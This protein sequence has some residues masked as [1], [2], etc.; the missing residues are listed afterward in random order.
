MKKILIG[1]QEYA[2]KRLTRI[3]VAPFGS[4]LVK[5]KEKVLYRNDFAIVWQTDRICEFYTSGRKD[6]SQLSLFHYDFDDGRAEIL[7][8]E[9]SNLQEWEK[10]FIYLFDE[11][12][13]F[14]LYT[15]KKLE[16][17][18]VPRCRLVSESGITSLREEMLN[19]LGMIDDR[20]PDRILDMERLRNNEDGNGLLLEAVY[21]R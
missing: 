2:V 15:C 7:F 16:R 6:G 8:P 13:A 1:N 19:T 5:H 20:L 9:E 18:V 14:L 17:Y 4:A 11:H 12:G 10:L 3:V 21:E